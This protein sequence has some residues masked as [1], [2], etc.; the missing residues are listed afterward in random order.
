MLVLSRKKSDAIVIN[1]DIKITVLDVKGTTVRLGIEAPNEVKVWRA[2][3]HQRI[4]EFEMPLLEASE[5][6]LGLQ[7]SIA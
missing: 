5:T 6:V 7:Q 3:L 4:Q 2:E 1:G